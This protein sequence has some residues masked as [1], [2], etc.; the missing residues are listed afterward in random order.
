[1]PELVQGLTRLVAGLDLEFQDLFP[2]AEELAGPPPTAGLPADV[3]EAL[4][5]L[6]GKLKGADNLAALVSLPDAL[7][8]VIACL[9]RTLAAADHSGA[10]E[11]ASWLDELENHLDDSAAAAREMA[12]RLVRLAEQVETWTRE[13][14]FAFL[15]NPQRRLFSIGFNIEDGQLDRAHYDMLASE[16]RLASYLAIAKGDVDHRTWFCLSRPMTETAGRVGLLSWGGTMFEYLMP[17]LFQRQY[18]GSLI[19]ESCRAAVARQIEFGRQNHVP[20]GISESAFSALAANSDYH[21]RSFGV[22][23]LGL[24]RGLAKDLVVS[25]YSTFLALEQDPA[26]AYENLHALSREGGLGRWGYYDAL[27]YTPE[28][29]PADKRSLPVR[30]YMAHHQGMCLAALANLLDAGSVQRRFH[31]HPL[32]RAAELLLQER[33]PAAAPLVEVHESLATAI[34]IPKAEGELVSRR[35]AGYETATPRTHLLSNGQYAVM[36]TS[37]GGGY[38]RHRDHAVTRWRSD[39]TCDHWGQFLYLRDVRTGRLWS[40]TYQP[41][42]ARPDAYHVTY[43]IDKAEYHR[44]DGAIETHLEVAVSPESQAEMR[45][46]KITNYGT[47][48][49]EIEITSY[50]EVVLAP[51]AADEA[52]PAFHKLF[53]ETEYIA[54]ELALAARRRPR[55]SAQQ[56]PWAVHVL[57]PGAHGASG[58]EFESSR[59]KFLGRGRTPQAPAALEPGARLTGACGAVLDP[60]FALRTRAVIQP[61]ETATL[62]FTTA[63]AASREEALALADQFHELRVVQR[64]FEM[65]WAYSQ[66]ELRHLH[67]SP[68]KAHLFQRL[69]SALLYPDPAWR[70]DGATLAANR[71][72][73]SGLWRYGISGDLPILLVHITRPDHLDVVRDL[74]VALQYWRL[75]GL[76][77]DLVIVNDHPGSYLDALHEQLVELVNELHRHPD[78]Q[79]AHVSLLR[80]AQIPR[81]DHTL[82][83]A[84]AAVVVRAERG[85]LAKQLELAAAQAKPKAAPALR[86]RPEPAAEGA[87][88]ASKNGSKP[89]PPRRLV[90]DRRR[91]FFNGW[92]GFVDGERAYQIDLSGGRHTPLP[93]SNVIAN[94]RFGCL[95]TESGGGYTWA[96]NSREF[97]L[98]SW[99]NDPIA[100]MPSEWFYVRDERQGTIYL[101]LPQP[102]RDASA[103]YVV[104]H[105]R[106]QSRFRHS[107]DGLEFETQIAVAAADPVKFVCANIHNG[108]REAKVVSLTYY[109]EWV[110]G[111]HRRETQ[112]HVATS[113]DPQSGALI[114]R[115]RYHSQFSENVSFLHVLGPNAI[116]TGDRAEFLGRNRDPIEPAAL[117]GNF[118]AGKTGAGL[119][120]CGAVQTRLALAAGERAKVVFLLGAGRNLDEVQALVT[121]YRS[122]Q[123]VDDEI[124]RQEKQWEATLGAI[125][126]RT[127]N[128]ALD[129][130]VNHWLLYQTL[131]CRLWARSAYYQSGGAYG[132]RDQLQDVMALV[133]SRPDLAREHLLRAAARQ[134]EQGDVQHWWHPPSGHGT[135]T[136]FS[137][138]YLW[139][140]LVTSHYVSVTGDRGVLD[141]HASLL[142][143]P[144]LEPHEQER[145]ELPHQTSHTLSLYQHCKLTFD[146]AF[147]LGPHGLPLMG[148]GDW[149]D[150]MNRVGALGQGES[151]WVGWFLLVILREFLP[152]MCERGDR[153]EADRLAARAAELRQNLETHAWD[154]QWYRRAYFDDGTPLGSHQNY[155][156]R[157]DSLSQS[158]AVFAGADRSRARMAMDAVWNELVRERARLVLLLTPPF[159]KSPLDPGYIKGYL[160]GI[161]ENGGQYTH[162]ALWTIQ[163]FAQLGDAERAMELF[164]LI[165]PVLHAA[166]PEGVIRYQVEPYVAAADVYGVAPHIGRGGWTWYTGSAAWMYRVALESILGFE[167][168]GQHLRVRPCIPADWPAFEIDFRRGRA[169]YKITYRNGPNFSRPQVWL[170]GERHSGEEIELSDEQQSHEILIDCSAGHSERS[171]AEDG[172]ARSAASRVG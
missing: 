60:V 172:T 4:G 113:I 118:P 37:T 8:E 140:P 59:E 152:L 50:A 63:V 138:D 67:L 86:H 157:I 163:A 166:T 91:S 10:R 147:R 77:V 150:G 104:E 111:V 65:A 30:C 53:V 38:S 75:H 21:Y 154:G 5:G 78:S 143:S 160:P 6:L 84:A 95:V 39:P 28:R 171:L 121:R 151:V 24:K 22:P 146:R 69:A 85:T 45:Q 40:A 74:L 43:S 130:L 12:G 115:N 133:Y 49:A 153:E 3:R 109:V 25:P 52:H 70:A 116:A 13:M 119:D 103:E 117:A 9:R 34:Q 27:D 131:A 61:H 55:D 141:E 99:A 120:P 161:R 14:D 48:A 97:K 158:W 88:L 110:L 112:M 170:D 1:M 124:A 156:C 81:E 164:D 36:L 134:F 79:S 54:E 82:L 159:D 132:F 168:R 29:L 19:A 149:N 80:G 165:N 93:W 35:L 105:R 11:I 71:Q 145:Y 26:A 15:Y 33:F 73:Q 23:G 137:D 155:E 16:A 66:V 136:R 2:W 142:H 41:T 89:A 87:M 64:A 56:A 76:T 125:Q 100:D 144:P 139:L 31:S 128:A 83:A 47:Q 107:Q 127:P 126:V 18:A 169:T 167:L 129:V 106:G 92:G 96:E 68:A 32:G 94:P 20:W 62:A 44:R 102:G 51:P 162:G 148:C 42:R 114:A 57:A 98:T 72:G 108:T 101:P 123:E 122:P 90:A 46:L 7:A 58:V 135:R 17:Q